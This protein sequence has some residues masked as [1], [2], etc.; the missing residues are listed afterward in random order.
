MRI[1]STPTPLLALALCLAGCP[2]STPG[3]A[4]DAGG[5]PAAT[6]SAAAAP[7]GSAAAAPTAS[8]RVPPP[9][10]ANALCKTEGEKTWATGATRVTG[11]TTK[12]MAD[13]R[14]AVGL[15]VGGTPHVL[16]FAASGEGELLKV[17]IPASSTLAKPVPAAEGTRTIL[18]VTPYAVEG[19]VAR[20][21][22]DFKDELK[23]KKRRVIC[24]PADK[25]E[26][27]PKFDG[28]PLLDR[29]PKPTGEERAQL[30]KTV[31]G[32]DEGYH[33]L[34]DCRTFIDIKKNETYI[35]GSELRA[36][37]AGGDKTTYK[38]SLVVATA[39]KKHE[40]HLRDI[41]LKGDPPQDTAF[42]MPVTHGVK[43]GSYLLMS[44]FG[45]SL[46]AAFLKA[47][48]SPLTKFTTYSGFP[49]RPE[50]NRDDEGMT[51]MVTAVSVGKDFELRGMRIGPKNELPK[52]MVKVDTGDADA[53]TA[54]DP[55]FL[56]DAKNRRWVSYIA[57]VRGKGQLKLIGIDEAFKPIGK[58]HT[59]TN[60]AE[61]ASEPR[62][63]PLDDGRIQLV[64]I[65]DRP[66]G[67]GEL[68]SEI[69]RCDDPR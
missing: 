11:L 67:S 5:T 28:T 59:V 63:V 10:D 32:G 25:E 24:G 16:V 30:F 50:A 52:S 45:G 53:T 13:G 48:K 18:R 33:E 20:A 19:N 43:D 62:L 12:R 21:Y 49:T 15:A 9:P 29:D 31:E 66:G 4:P 17:A 7:S 58:A 38:A 61:G 54:T 3:A 36:L 65:V 51:M 35:I 46:V 2:E 34:R 1:L 22:V 47:D 60:E 42:D 37:D 14:L 39:P 23:D 27:W 26:G 57:G 41:E 40:M 44:R 69:L 55:M 56:R 8:S 6:T 68:R 64:Y